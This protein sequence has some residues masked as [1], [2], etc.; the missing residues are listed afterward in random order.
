MN[1]SGELVSIP[2]CLSTSVAV[3]RPSTEP[4]SKENGVSVGGIVGISCAIIIVVVGISI[5]VI[6]VA[7]LLLRK[8]KNQKEIQKIKKLTLLERYIAMPWCLCNI[9]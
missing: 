9:L 5:G 6:F 8:R 4:Q 7:L 1:D 2:S 3:P